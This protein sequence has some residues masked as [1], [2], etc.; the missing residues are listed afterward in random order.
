MSKEPHQIDKQQCRTSFNKAAQRYDE[1][2]VLQREVGARML[3]RLDLIKLN[4]TTI[5]DIGAGTGVCAHALGKRYPHANVIAL[6]IAPEMLTQ[7]KNKR[8]WLTKAISRKHHYVCGDAEQLPMADNSVDLLF[9]NMAIQWCTNL[10][11]TFAEFKRVLKHGGTLL[12]STTGP[13]TLTE[14]RSSWA[15][16]DDHSHVHTFID[17]HDIGDALMR[18][19]FND[20][21]M[22]VENFTLTY[23]TVQQLM[24]EL[25]VLGAHNVSQTR[26]PGL[27]GKQRLQTMLAAYEKYRNN[28]VLP[29]TYE[30]VYGHAWN[31]TDQAAE[32]DH[33]VNV[34]P[35]SRL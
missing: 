34:A 33:S 3:D 7:A 35:P 31:L 20:P 26:T 32:R 27:T 23:S 9:S 29:A 13:D 11:Q 30:V 6:D 19:G 16:A 15:T 22:D 28:G 4:P 5:L 18:N 8:N 10:D 25:K 24:K 1:V 21:V 12:F 2:A 14:L 17:M